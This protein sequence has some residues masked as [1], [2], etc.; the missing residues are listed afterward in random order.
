[1]NDAKPL[2]E[3]PCQT[4]REVNMRLIS[5]EMDGNSAGDFAR[6]LISERRTRDAR[7]GPYLFGEPAWDMLLDLYAAHDE[8]K[9]LSVHSVCLASAAPPSTALRWLSR[10]E[11]DRL[12]VRTPDATDRRRTLVELTPKA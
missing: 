5:S 9:K 3:R 6:R 1:M 4:H 11:S 12:I 8:K 2:H 7:L 10:L